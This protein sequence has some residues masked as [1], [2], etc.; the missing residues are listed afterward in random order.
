[1]AG[2][3]ANPIEK[4]AIHYAEQKAAATAILNK[5]LAETTKILQDYLLQDQEETQQFVTKTVAEV[6]SANLFSADLTQWHDAVE[7]E[8]EHYKDI[9]R[10]ETQETEKIM[11]EWNNL[12]GQLDDQAEQIAALQKQLQTIIAEL[13]SEKA[14]KLAEQ[15]ENAA[16]RKTLEGNLFLIKTL[17]ESTSRKKLLR[18]EKLVI[19]Y[20]ELVEDNNRTIDSLNQEIATFKTQKSDLSE[21]NLRLDKRITKLTE[22]LA[23]YKDTTETQTKTIEELTARIHDITQQAERNKNDFDNKIE[24]IQ[25]QLREKTIKLNDMTE[26]FLKYSVRNNK[27]FEENAELQR[28]LQDCRTTPK[29]RKLASHDD[30]CANCIKPG[31]YASDCPEPKASYCKSCYKADVRQGDGQSCFVANKE[32]NLEK[33]KKAAPN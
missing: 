32:A 22:Q 13:Q 19:Q 16:L 14:A 8:A 11:E 5:K 12:L 7:Q 25:K 9:I 1:M 28:Q 4:A 31:H 2:N 20:Q 10:R 18:A 26:Q 27:L 15:A 17:E 23:E 33:R 29:R 6:R 30:L 21:N 24:S 3:N